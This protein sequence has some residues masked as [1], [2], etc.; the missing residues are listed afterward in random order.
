MLK[1]TSGIRKAGR[2][3]SDKRKDNSMQRRC[4]NILILIVALVFAAVGCGCDLDFA[5]SGQNAGISYSD[6]FEE[7][8]ELILRFLYVGQADC[9]LISLPDGTTL[10][11]DG[12]NDSDG[13]EIAGYIKSL[14]I[15]RLDLVVAT[16]PH[17]DHIGGL[18]KILKEF[19]AGAIYA[20]ELPASAEPDTKNYRDFV[21]AAKG[22]DCGLS[23]LAAGQTMYNAGGVTIDCLSPDARDVYSDLNNYSIVLRITYGNQNFLLMGDAE[24]EVESVLLHEGYT[25]S[26]TLIKA[27][28]HGSKTSSSQKFIA[29]VS[30]EFAILSCG[31]ENTYG[32]P[33]AQTLKTFAAMG[34][35]VFSLS[36]CGS[37][38]AVC[39]GI[40]TTVTEYGELNL[41]GSK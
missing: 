38:F 14:G 2:C 19:P 23:A 40:G 31:R 33:H 29:A 16:H 13:E 3:K 4:K 32:F 1:K 15:D 18:D 30:P 37:V 12:G 39:D 9:T 11:V 34:T 20:P 21:A 10:L 25:L 7:T 41:D 6:R 36:E 22:Q 27:G 28:H 17:E 8:G 35:Q 24:T 26:A 5:S